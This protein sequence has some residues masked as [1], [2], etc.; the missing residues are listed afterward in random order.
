MKKKIQNEIVEDNEEEEKVNKVQNAIIEDNEEEENNDMKNNHIINNYIENN[1]SEEDDQIDK[2]LD[3]DIKK[4]NYNEDTILLNNFRATFGLMR[5]DYPDET[6]KELLT[7]N[8]NDINKAFASLIEKEEEKE[9]T[10]YFNPNIMN[11]LIKRFRFEFQLKDK[12][13][14]S[15]LK[16]KNALIKNQGD[17][18]KTFNSLY[19]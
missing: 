17:F 10:E 5:S 9:K 7:K 13:L 12:Q 14:V 6:L 11:N 19:N 8:N 3:E 18:N 1:E 15:D 2:Y 4:N 16:I